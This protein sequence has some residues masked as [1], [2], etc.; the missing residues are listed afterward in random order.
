MK[1]RP[2]NIYSIG[3]ALLFIACAMTGCVVNKGRNYDIGFTK[4]EDRELDEAMVVFQQITQGRGKYA[5]RARYYIAECYRLQARWGEA[6]QQFQMVADAEPKSLLGAAARYRIAQ[7]EQGLEALKRI[8]FFHVGFSDPSEL[9]ADKL[10][11]LGSIYEDKLE[12]YDSAIKAYQ[13]VIEKFPGTLKAAQ[14]QFNIGNIYLYKTYDYTKAF[15]ELKKVNEENYPGLDFLAK[16]AEDTL[17]NFN[18]ISKEIE[19]HQELIRKLQ[20]KKI[21]PGK[22]TGY[23][24]YGRRIEPAR[25]AFLAIGRKWR[26]LKNYPRAIKAYRITIERLPLH[27][28]VS[29]E[30]RY[31]IAEIYQL[32]Q[33]R[34]VEA[35]ESLPEIHLHA[36]HGFQARSGYL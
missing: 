19:K 11:E 25:E 31:T 7:I 34:Y 32:D 26:Q 33:G 36:S 13:S 14:A 8:E 35:I 4:F 23:D 15:E 16:E 29:S 28:G 1:N 30:A 3:L 18:M 6:I 24:I 22:I 12:D 21:E 2:Q 27:L 10:L 5:K 20:K 17:R 9:A